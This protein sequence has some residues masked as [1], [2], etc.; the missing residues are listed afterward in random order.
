MD[1]RE[2]EMQLTW[3]LVGRHRCS[4]ISDGMDRASEE[5]RMK[6]DSRGFEIV[7]GQFELVRADP[8][9]RDLP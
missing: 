1:R 8:R 6:R 7:H 2:L 9:I 5:T 3:Y 4:T